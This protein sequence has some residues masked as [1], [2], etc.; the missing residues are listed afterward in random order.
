MMNSLACSPACYSVVG[1]EM[2]F[3][4]RLLVILRLWEIVITGKAN[5]DGDQQPKK[6]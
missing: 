5:L 4:L 2:L 1:V 6:K 3:V